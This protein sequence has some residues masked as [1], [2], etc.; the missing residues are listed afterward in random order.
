[1]GAENRVT[2]G[3][4]WTVSHQK[5]DKVLL[6]VKSPRNFELLHNCS[7]NN[8]TIMYLINVFISW[9]LAW[10]FSCWSFFL[11][12]L[13]IDGKQ[14]TIFFSH[15][16][17]NQIIF[18]GDF[19]ARVGIIENIVG[20]YFVAFNNLKITSNFFKNKDTDT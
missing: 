15:N 4:T 6:R 17:T 16:K 20:Y 8:A 14:W 11:M 12:K 3:W 1:M 19:N 2:S 9:E 10:S 7:T 13:Y 5:W 18:M